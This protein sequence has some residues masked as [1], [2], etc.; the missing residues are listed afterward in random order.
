MLRRSIIGVALMLTSAWS[1]VSF[2]Q[3]SE[4]V[5]A[6]AEETER[7]RAVRLFREAA[8]H[9]RAGRFRVAVELLRESYQLHPEPVVLFNL[10]RSLEGLGELEQAMEAYSRFIE[11]SPNAPDRG[12]VEARIRTLERLVREQREREEAARRAREQA[13]EEEQREPEPP[14][15]PSGPD[16]IDAA[17]IVVTGLGGAGLIVGAIVAGAAV[18]T[19]NQWVDAPS[20]A[21]AVQSLAEARDL[22]TAANVAFAI[23]GALA[24][25]G[26]IWIIVDAADSGGG[27]AG[28]ESVRVGLDGRGAHVEVR[29]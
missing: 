24:L 25:I 17:A 28:T 2:A 26:G 4:G 13:E 18:A 11:L 21:S 9:Y 14:P 8:E 23:G 3:T 1:Q 29:F 16:E 27:S 6:P 12:A 19:H 5:E 20:H 22:A 7:D 10:A 15:L